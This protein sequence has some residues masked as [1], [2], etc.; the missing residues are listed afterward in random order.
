MKRLKQI[1]LTALALCALSANALAFDD[2]QKGDKKPPKPDVKIEKGQKPP[3]PPP[4][5]NDGGNRGG[6]NNKKP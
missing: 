1:I 6:N 3:P 5:K 2:G 4:P